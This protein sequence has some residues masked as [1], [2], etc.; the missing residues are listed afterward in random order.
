MIV[1]YG[2]NWAFLDRF[3]FLSIDGSFE[4]QIEFEYDPQVSWVVI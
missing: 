3:C 4:Y 1:F 2:Q